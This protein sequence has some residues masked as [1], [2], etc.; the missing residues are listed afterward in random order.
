MPYISQ[1]ALSGVFR[2]PVH[3][4]PGT[5]SIMTHKSFGTALLV[6]AYL[7]I[8]TGHLLCARG[9]RSIE[10]HSP[11]LHIITECLLSA[12]HW[13]KP[14]SNSLTSLRKSRLAGMHWFVHNH[15]GRKEQKTS[16]QPRSDSKPLL[17]QG[18]RVL[19]GEAFCSITALA[20][21][22]NFVLIPCGLTVLE[23]CTYLDIT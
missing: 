16:I 11:C 20:S 4:S 13:V 10:K 12:T 17:S 2:C 8:F 7:Q 5:H 21:A 1:L 22:L 15:G 6:Y 19:E 9:W 14:S 23:N 3:S 18:L